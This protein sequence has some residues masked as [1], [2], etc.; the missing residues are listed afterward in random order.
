MSE[1]EASG[2]ITGVA[3]LIGAVAA[4]LAALGGLVGFIGHKDKDKDTRVHE[5]TGSISLKGGKPASSIE[6]DLIG[7]PCFTR[8]SPNGYFRFQSCAEAANLPHPRIRIYLSGQDTPCTATLEKPP[9]ASDIEVDATACN[10]TVKVAEPEKAAKAES[11]PVPPPA[12]DP[13]SALHAAGQ[14]YI[15][16]ASTKTI[17]E[18]ERLA[19]REAS[20]IRAKVCVYSSRQLFATAAGPVSVSE[21][22]TLATQYRAHASVSPSAFPVI[23]QTYQSLGKCFEP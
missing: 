1:D 14:R 22:E 3:K 8:T 16:L 5:L 20:E 19:Q 15:Q 12:P 23:G 2:G 9:K 7:T 17:E 21:A 11:A 10:P 18:A 4:L 13:A 6:L